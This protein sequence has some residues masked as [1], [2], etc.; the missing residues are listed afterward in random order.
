MS[1]YF[2]L[3]LK[4]LKGS[5]IKVPIY[6]RM[7]S[8]KT[9]NVTTMMFIHTNEYWSFLILVSKYVAAGFSCPQNTRKD[10]KAGIFHSTGSNDKLEARMPSTFVSTTE[11]SGIAKLVL[12]QHKLFAGLVQWS[13]FVRSLG[14]LC[15]LVCLTIC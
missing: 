13:P 9:V 7:F 3:V 2:P 4:L 6:W 1:A 12:F 8:W 15:V 5:N 11:S 14:Q 10:F